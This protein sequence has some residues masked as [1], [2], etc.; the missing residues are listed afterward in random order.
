AVHNSGDP[1][2][3]TRSTRGIPRGRSTAVVDSPESRTRGSRLMSES[4]LY[5]REGGIARLTFNRPASL[6]AMG[7]EMGQRWRD[8]AHEVTADPTVGAI[9][10]DANGPAF[11]AGG[12]VVEMA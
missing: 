9:I 8:L 1:E 12:D 5:R 7:F 3:R 11:C 4:I 10:L 2:H 6:N